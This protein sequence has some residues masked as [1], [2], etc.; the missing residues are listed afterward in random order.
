MKQQCSNTLLQ[1]VEKP[2]FSEPIPVPK[3]A[4]FLQAEAEQITP[5]F[6][7]VEKRKDFVPSLALFFF[8]AS[9]VILHRSEVSFCANTQNILNRIFCIKNLLTKY[10]C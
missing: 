4:V 1:P 3:T 9:V 2:L 5:L 6:Y 7:C 10:T 8:Q